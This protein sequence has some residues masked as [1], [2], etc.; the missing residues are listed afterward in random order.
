MRIWTKAGMAP[1][2]FHES[3]ATG[4][5]ARL[6]VCWPISGVTIWASLHCSWR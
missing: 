4:G 1:V 5:S 2:G 6:G 3:R